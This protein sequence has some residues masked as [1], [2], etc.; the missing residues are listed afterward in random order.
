MPKEGTSDAGRL[1]ATQQ[2]SDSSFELHSKC[3]FFF[4]IDSVIGD[5]IQLVMVSGSEGF[6]GDLSLSKLV[7]RRRGFRHQN[8]C[9]RYKPL[10]GVEISQQIAALSKHPVM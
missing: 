2:S 10:E 9:K 7:S 5:F 4:Y 1:L 6:Q 8:A 3:W